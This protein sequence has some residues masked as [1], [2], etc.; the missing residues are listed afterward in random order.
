MSQHCLPVVQ[1][2]RLPAAAALYLAAACQPLS[3]FT[4][5]LSPAQAQQST[6]YD[7]ARVQRLRQAQ[8]A[9]AAQLSRGVAPPV[10]GTAVFPPG[11]SGPPALSAATS[12]AGRPN[13][14]NPARLPWL[15]A[16]NEDGPCVGTG[17]PPDGAVAAVV[18]VT[19]NRRVAVSP[20]W[21]AA[22]GHAVVSKGVCLCSML[23]GRPRPCLMPLGHALAALQGQVPRKDA[24][25]PVCS[26]WPQQQQQAR[27]AP[28]GRS[29]HALCG[30]L[31]M[32]C[33]AAPALSGACEGCCR[34]H[35]AA[36]TATSDSDGLS[37]VAFPCAPPSVGASFRCSSAKT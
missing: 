21:L 29:P 23:V 18:V 11:E 12:T 16:G 15:L 25:Q 33:A 1:R 9:A 4:R 5:L 31:A 36:D 24:F 26:S 6:N 30:L 3:P 32:S 7:E 34:G 14:C 20:N 2:R 27:G 8:Q 10:Q 22:L 19:F 13:T 28:L 35:R 37:S 17:P